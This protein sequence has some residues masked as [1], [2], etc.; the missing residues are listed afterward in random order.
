[1]SEFEQNI[2]VFIR[3]EVE[4]YFNMQFGEFKSQ[5]GQV[6]AFC[7]SM[8][9]KQSEFMGYEDIH[10]EFGWSIKKLT[11]WKRK[12]KIICVFSNGS[13]KNFFE[14]RQ[15]LEW[16]QEYNNPKTPKPARPKFLDQ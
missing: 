14:R 12:G 6:A 2:R 5:L 10:N 9:N 3:E 15:V 16:F 8:Q 11:E 13:G 4:D 1:M 7:A